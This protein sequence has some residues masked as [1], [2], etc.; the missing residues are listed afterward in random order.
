MR[1]TIDNEGLISLADMECRHP[2]AAA[3]AVAFPPG[4]SPKNS[5]GYFSFFLS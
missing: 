3:V 2:A 1:T 5:Y 4:S